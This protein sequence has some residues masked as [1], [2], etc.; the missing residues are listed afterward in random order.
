MSR[1]PGKAANRLNSLC[2][3]DPISCR[4]R[5]NIM[6]WPHFEQDTSVLGWPLLGLIDWVCK[7]IGGTVPEGM[8]VIEMPPV[9]RSAVWRPKQVVDLWDSLMRGLPIGTFYL[10]SANGD[11]DVVDLRTGETRRFSGN[12]FD[13]LDGQQRVRALLVG[14]VGF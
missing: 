7:S 4:W 9:Q 1:F 12:G 10:V 5:I 11:R 14:A 13:L 8:P 6:P 3:A 2:F